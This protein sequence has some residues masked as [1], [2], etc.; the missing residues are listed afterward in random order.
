MVAIK[1]EEFGVISEGFII[2][3]LPAAIAEIKGPKVRLKGK[4]QGETI[5]QTPLGSYM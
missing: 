2:A 4:F 5:R 1:A 3:V